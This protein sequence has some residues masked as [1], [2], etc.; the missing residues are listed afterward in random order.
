M[1]A[2]HRPKTPSASPC[3]PWLAGAAG[4]QAAR[5]GGGPLAAARDE[6]RTTATGTATLGVAEQEEGPSSPLGR[7]KRQGHPVRWAVLALGGTAGLI[8]FVAF[9]RQLANDA[10]LVRS[11]LIGKAAPAFALPGLDGGTVSSAALAGGPAVVNFWASWCVPCRDEAPYLEAFSR[12][13]AG[14]GVHIAGIAYHDDA[15]HAR[16]FRREFGLT[17]PQALDP[18]SRASIDYGVFGVPETYVLD[19]DGVVRAKLV[20]AVGPRTL[21]D[22]MRKVLAG[23]THVSR[24][25]RYR[26]P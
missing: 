20:G 5:A 25:G 6:G 24:N 8:L 9:A 18:D 16:Q 14:R 10:T 1:R 7:R 22:V 19:A 17:Y 4:V 26:Q 2:G 3:F 15:D 13:W 11:P 12:R 23:Q 21:D